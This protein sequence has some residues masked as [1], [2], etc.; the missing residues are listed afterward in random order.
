[1]EILYCQIFKHFNQKK[2]SLPVLFYVNDYFLIDKKNDTCRH[3]IE[4][5]SINEIPIYIYKVND[6]IEIMN[7]K[8]N[9]NLYIENKKNYNPLN[10]IRYIKSVG[11]GTRKCKY[12]NNTN[13]KCLIDK[14]QY[15][16]NI[17]NINYYI[18][19]L[20]QYFNY[21]KFE[22]PLFNA[23]LLNLI[24]H[25]K[26]LVNGCIANISDSKKKLFDDIITFLVTYHH[27]HHHHRS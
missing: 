21:F 22:I 16:R 11:N 12:F 6:I 17:R 7:L 15:H 27:H 5:V 1:M 19:V 13:I 20:M 25:H 8:N 10:F 2:V 23:L 26:N 14:L 18:T 3:L 24:L 9:Y 4:M